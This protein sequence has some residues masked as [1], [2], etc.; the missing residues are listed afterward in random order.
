MARTRNA[1]RD[2]ADVL[3]DVPDD[4]PAP[5][6]GPTWDEEIV[7]TIKLAKDLTYRV[8]KLAERVPAGAGDPRELL[9]GALAVLDVLGV[10]P[11]LIDPAG[12]A[13]GC[14]AGVAGMLG[15]SLAGAFGA[16]AESLIA[17]VVDALR[18]GA[19]D[20]GDP[21]VMPGEHGGALLAS[22][23]G[24]LTYLPQ[25]AFPPGSPLHR[26]PTLYLSG[27][28]RVACLG[29]RGRRFV[30]LSEIQQM[31]EDLERQRAAKEAEE[32]RAKEQ[33]DEHARALD[34]QVEEGFWRRRAMDLEAQLAAQRPQ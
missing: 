22:T 27:G 9:R 12:D 33:R 19:N 20:D 11:S 6:K 15:G 10:R 8:R 4:A 21:L 29:S 26:L 2:I 1:Q 14:G 18:R 34:R 7:Q 16:L 31:T 3:L 17:A 5:P 24:P 30:R 25:S 13:R 23:T 32:R 28:Q